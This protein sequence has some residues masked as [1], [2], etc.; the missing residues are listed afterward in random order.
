MSVIEELVLRLK[1][2]PHIAYRRETDSLG[3]LPT[4]DNGFTVSLIANGREITVFFNAS[5]QKFNLDEHEDLQDDE[6]LALELFV[7]GL[8]PKT[9]L[10]ETLRGETV[11]EW[12][13]EFLNEGEWVSSDTT[14]VFSIA[15]WKPKTVRYLQNN[16]I[17]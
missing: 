4:S 6:A 17:E 11:V 13:A 14:G 9:R 12:T 3:V 2:Y 7:E 8:S 1:K 10:K 16:F 15:F 5:H